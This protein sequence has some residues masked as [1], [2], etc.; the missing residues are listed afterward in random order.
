MNLFS[1]PLL[2][3]VV[4]EVA[5]RAIILG[6]LDFSLG[7]SPS[8]NRFGRKC[9]HCTYSSDLK[10]ELQAHMRE[11]VNERRHRYCLFSAVTGPELRRHERT[12]TGEK[13]FN[14]KY[15]G[16][17]FS[18]NGNLIKHEKALHTGDMPYKCHICPYRSIRRGFL[19]QHLQKIHDIFMNDSDK[20]L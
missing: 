11:H 19:L 9:P 10:L 16:R 17:A 13:P 12:H 5:N 14:C 15:C 2:D 8:S 6:D 7:P 18:D 4:D 3:S 20:P 1:E